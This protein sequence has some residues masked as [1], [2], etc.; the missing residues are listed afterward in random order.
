MT[1]IMRGAGDR[2][3]GMFLPSATAGA[4]I[5]EHG[6]PCSSCTCINDGG[7][8]RCYR[9]KFNCYG[10]CVRSTSCCC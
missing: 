4:C 8:I 9:N 7:I 1:K 3:L 10:R 5:P 2:L 6:Q